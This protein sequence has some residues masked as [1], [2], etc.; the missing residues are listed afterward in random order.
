MK[1]LLFLIPLALAAQ[2]PKPLTLAEAESLA[3]RNHP[4]V[5]AARL[6]SEAAEESTKQAK[7]ALSPIFSGDVTGSVADHGSRLGAGLLN[8]SSLFSRTAA[9]LNI[10]QT[11][12]DF[13]RTRT[14][15]AAAQ[16][17]ASAERETANS[18]RAEIVLR[19]RDAY[20]RA[21]L[22][23]S[24]LKVNQETVEARQLTLKQISAL[25]QSNLRSTL[26]VS[27]AELNL[28][29]AELLLDRARNDSR[30]SQVMLAAALGESA[31]QQYVLQDEPL[32]LPLDQTADLFVAHALQ[33]RPDLASLRLQERSAQSLA[34]SERRQGLPMLTA[35]GVAGF[36]GPH[37]PRLQPRY[38]GVGVN[39][40]IPIWNGRLFSSRQQEAELRAQVVHQEARD[41]EIRIARDIRAAWIDAENSF[42]RLALTAKVLNQAQ[43]TLKLAQTRYDLGLGSIVELSQAQLS[44]TSADVL[45]ARARYEYL[46]SRALL[47][48]H[49]GK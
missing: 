5:A 10:N 18:V 45:T 24:Q 28:A 13:G 47:D 33:A 43:R 26:D 2:A 46:L 48:F 16:F 23:Q 15:T 29:E 20:F 42:Q 34:E 3:I 6:R 38:A 21:L 30:S 9:G 37:D 35:R 17:R 8:A 31:G 41:L 40:N 4:R 44:R 19:V 39:L 12:F 14:L 36:Y 27:F 7:A 22:A 11:L 25:A 32:P 1:Y 49:A